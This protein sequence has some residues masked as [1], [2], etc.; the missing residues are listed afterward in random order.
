MQDPEPTKQCH[1]EGI[2]STLM[3][4]SLYVL[5]RITGQLTKESYHLTQNIDVEIILLI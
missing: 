3:T 5:Q 1:P 2:Y 4:S